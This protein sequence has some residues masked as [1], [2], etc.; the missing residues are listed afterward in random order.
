MFKDK[1]KQREANR[2]A[3]KEY[4]D[5]KKGITVSPTENVIPESEGITEKQGITQ[6]IT[7]DKLFIPTSSEFTN[8]FSPA[9]KVGLKG[10][11]VM[12]IESINHPGFHE[13]TFT[14]VNQIFRTAE[15]RALLEGMPV[16]DWCRRLVI[17]ACK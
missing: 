2:K 4:R 15:G 1:E 16:E 6:S 9:P 13:I 5:R 12:P 11:K 3:N 7:E 14:L 17:R 8:H 10:G